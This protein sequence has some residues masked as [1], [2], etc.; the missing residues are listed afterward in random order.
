[1]AGRD[2]LRD[3]FF[4]EC[5]DLLEVMWDGFTRMEGAPDDPETI[6][7]VFRAVHSIKGG[8]GAFGFQP[9]VRFSHALEDV[10]DDLRNGK[11][12]DLTG[13]MPLLFRA[14]DRLMDLVEAE[15]SGS[16]FDDTASEHRALLAELAA[17]RG[18]QPP[19][20]TPDPA[21]DDDGGFVPMALDLMPLGA[22][23]AE[24]PQ[25][26][27][28]WRLRFTPERNLYTS[29]NDPIALM[30]ALRELGE[31]RVEVNLANLPDWDGAQWD[32]AYLSWTLT[33]DGTAARDDIAEIFEFVSEDAR[34][35]FLD[36]PAPPRIA[37]APEARQ[38]IRVDLERV[39]R[40]IN[41]VG[42]LVISEA[43]LSQSLTQSGA[44]QHPAVVTSL[45]QLKQLSTELQE[46]IMAIRA[47]SIKPLFQR[48]SRIVREAAGASGCEVRLV[49][50]GET[51]EVDKT[52]VERLAD[53]LTHMLRNAVDHGIE[54]P[55]VRVAAG[56]ARQGTVLLSAAHRSGQV[57]IEI[58][59]DGAG[60][61]TER[62]LA[63]AIERGLVPPDTEMSEQD[64]FALLFEP[65]FSTAEKIS[66][67]SGRGV[68]MDVVRSEIRALGGRVTLASVRGRGTT[69]TIS[70][71]LT[72][73]V[74]EGM[75]VE[76]AG[77][78]LVVPST[79]LRETMRASDAAIHRMGAGGPVLSMRGELIPLVDLGATLGYRARS[80]DM[81]GRSLLL[82]ESSG[83]RRA[84]LSVDGILGQREVVIKGLSENYGHVPGIAAATILGD[85]SIALI[86][87]V[88]QV[89]RAEVG[90]P[91]AD[92]LP[93]LMS[94]AGAR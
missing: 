79:A 78:T 27:A 83:N 55:E 62:V 47:Q 6:N 9:L 29:G 37:A 71:P 17:A 70:L 58:V 93:P 2:S 38:S 22:I 30:R 69:A 42:E 43:M 92:P 44:G 50:E 36:D 67:L 21:E 25:D 26:R 66:D 28:P 63:K 46:R 7:A 4:Q 8:A 53:P 1:M 75:L 74:V 80:D 61:D 14:G 91:M 5:E 54:T 89:A 13:L 24:D 76:V 85:G 23:G 18:A 12:A 81:S 31:L 19:S 20:A 87:D 94:A 90:S 56:K 39:D 88:D 77:E 49:T 84:A 45:G 68:G 34:L 60:I 72:L 57:I 86:V 73:A 59:D 48:M 51:T 65:G 52:V 3:T 16:A 32:G 64:I 35:E 10:L 15:R 33:L 41:L 82:V 40:L 11:L